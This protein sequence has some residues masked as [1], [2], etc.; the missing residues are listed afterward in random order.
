[1]AL[2]FP[3][4]GV[5]QVGIVVRD[6]DRAMARYWTNFGIG[7]WRVYTYAAPLVREMTYRGRRQDFSMRIAL[8][9]AGPTIV[10]LIESLEGPNIYE[11]FLREHGEGIHHVMSI[12][13]DFDAAVEGMVAAGYPVLQSGRGFGA[14]GSGGY[15]Y[16]DTVAD[17]ALLLEVVEIPKVRVTP[18]LVYPADP[19]PP[20]A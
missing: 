8:T 6:L 1:M 13:D 19:E 9:Q 16:F 10:E 2:P 4:A 3:L 17:L 5:H 15:A 11:E 20:R 12:V 18:D 14:D 7:P